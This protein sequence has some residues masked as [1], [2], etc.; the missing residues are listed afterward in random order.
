MTETYKKRKFVANGDSAPKVSRSKVLSPFRIVGNVSNGVPFAVGTLGT[1]FYI[2]T[3]VGKSFQIYDANTLHLLFVSEHETDSAIT[4]LATH[5]QHVFAGFGNK[6]G[7]YRRG[8]LEHFI[9]LPDSD[10]VVTN[11]CIFG[12]FLCVSSDRTVYVYKR[13]PQ[14]KFATIFYTKIAISK[15]QGSEIVCLIHLPTYLNKVIVVTKSNLLL[16]NVKSG[17]LLFTSDEFSDTITTAEAAPALDVLGLGCAS[18]EIILY[19]VRKARKVRSIKTPVYVSSLSFRTDG[20][21]HLAVGASNGDLIFYDLDRRSRIHVLRNVHGEHFGGISKVS[22]LNGQPIVV[23]SGDDNQLKEYVFD[24]SLS[25]GD[26]ETVVQPPR[27]LRSR[28]GHSQPPTSILF[29]DNQSHFI[30]SASSDRSL[31]GFSLR[32]DAQSQ[33]LS[34]RLHKKKDGGRLAGNTLKEKFPEI[35]SMSIENARQGEWENVVTAHKDEHFARTWNLA[36]KRVGRWTLATI[37]DGLA[38]SVA[39]SSCGNFGFVG[40]SN[41]GIGVYNLE[42]GLPRKKYRLHKKAVTG[43]AVDGMNRKMVSCGL[44]GIVGFYDFSK[45]AFLGKLQLDAPITSM[46]YHRSSDLFALALDDFSIIVVDAVT[47]KV[48]RQLWGHTNRISSFDFSPDGRWIVSTS[49]DASIRTWDLPTGTCIDGV[50][51]DSVASNIKFSPNG[52]FVATTHV[53]GNGISIWT[54]RAQF[55]PLPTRQIDEEEFAQISLSSSFGN[56][57]TSVLDGAFESNDTDESEVG[58]IGHYKSVDQINGDMITLSLGPRN[59]FKTLLNLDVIRQRSKPVEPPKKPEKA[60]FFLKLSGEK[61]GDDA[62]VREKNEQ[63]NGEDGQAQQEIEKKS[64]EAEEQIRKH[65]PIATAFE[66]RFTRLLR[67]G[68]S[69]QDYTSFLDELVNLSPASVDM[70]IRSLNSFEP[71]EELIWFL[72]ALTEGLR[73]NKNFELY[74]AFMSLLLKAHGDVIHANS[75]N[76]DLSAALKMWGATHTHDKKIDEIVKFCS[77]VANFV[78]SA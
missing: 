16:Y 24:P 58:D 9:E 57:G 72:E 71:F 44:D 65:K 35:L 7:I 64:T 15:L 47:Q 53:I 29:A 60:P 6:V 56:S 27:F 26:A 77:S 33:E 49:L 12:D 19:N 20:S 69:K 11:I 31:W 68:H 18:G 32:K 76:T 21:A 50:R 17:K 51:L 74:E 75:D 23:T 54:N 3:S 36:T 66:S 13:N 43:I 45:S 73:S 14:D 67:E 70:E 61:V 37:D 48:V 42:S 38:K 2:V 22:F 28:G 39:I 34:Q 55:K 10:A 59:K 1:T 41:G 5:F 52:D 62:V 25:Q 30:L 46:V 8:R 4:C 40:S 63:F 78:S